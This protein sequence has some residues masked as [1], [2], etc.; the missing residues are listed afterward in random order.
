[1]LVL[2]AAGNIAAREAMVSDFHFHDVKYVI[3]TSNPGKMG[4]DIPI[5]ISLG[6][7]FCQ[8]RFSVG[9][10]IDRCIILAGFS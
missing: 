3:F 9:D 5:R 6:Y 4:A 7:E 2:P 8:D 1:M 10:F